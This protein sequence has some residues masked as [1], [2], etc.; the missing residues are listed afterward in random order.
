[1][2][3][4]SPVHQFE[5]RFTPL[6]NITQISKSVI[7]PY[8][9]Q[10][11]RVNIERENTTK[12]KID[13]VY[14]NY[15]ITILW[16]RIVLKTGLNFE[17]LSENNSIILEPFFSIYKKF[18]ESD[19][20]GGLN[21]S[22]FH[23]IGINCKKGYY[24]EHF[25]RKFLTDAPFTLI[26][27][28]DCAIILE[29]DKN[30]SAKYSIKFGPYLGTPDLALRNITPSFEDSGEL[31]EKGGVIAELNILKEDSVTNFRAYKEMS[32]EASILLNRL[33]QTI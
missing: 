30:K 10:S 20:F 26:E 11:N 8:I 13:L 12:Q 25:K 3:V 31:S 1:M 33:W 24:L 2:S 27:T 21:N 6:I 28:D 16:D 4:I 5:L 23:V 7:A 17:K 32:Q 15:Q 18:S 19:D 14:D 9:R 29:S 22:L